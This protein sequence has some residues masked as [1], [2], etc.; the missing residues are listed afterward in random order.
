MPW[1]L[2]LSQ[3]QQAL[4]LR[5]GNRPPRRFA[6]QPTASSIAFACG[7]CALDVIDRNMPCSGS[8][9]RACR[10]DDRNVIWKEVLP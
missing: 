2:I 8:C 9:Y 7:R 4:L 5:R 3:D 10:I 6:A 1:Q